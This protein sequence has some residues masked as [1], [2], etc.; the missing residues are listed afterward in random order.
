MSTRVGNKS[1]LFGLLVDRPVLSLMVTLAILSVG[2]MALWNL[3]LR[4]V[5]AGMVSSRI[6]VWVPIAQA[7]TPRE[8]E[9]KVV[10]PT[11]ELLKTIPGLRE[12]RSN[13]RTRS[14]RFWI[15]L[16]DDLD[17]TLASAEVRDR[18]QRAKQSWPE[19]V[20]RYFTWREDA[21]AMPLAFFQ[22]LTPERN[23]DW[24][25]RIEKVVQPRLEAV[26]GVGRVEVWGHLEESIRIWFDR[27]KLI[28]HRVDYRE[29][30][31]RLA[32]DNFTEPVG[33]LQ[34]RDQR[35]LL[36]V[37]S[38]F[39]SLEEI[40]SYPVRTG[41]LLRDIARIER[42]P[43]VRNSLSRFNQRFCYSGMIR[44]T[45]GTNPVAT[46]RRVRETAAALAAE[47]ELSGLD[48][49]FMLDQGALIED[50]LKTLLKSL[51]QGG[52][53]ALLVLFLF[54]RNV[55]AT[56]GIGVAIPFTLLI[57]CGWLFFTGSTLNIL[58]MAGMTLAVG[59]VVDNSV[60]VMENIRRLR[61]EGVPLRQ[62]CVEGAREVG[63]AIT[64][65]TLT[66][67]VVFLPMVFM[68]S[69][70][71]TRIMF[72]AVGI[73][74]SVALLGS[75]FVAL[76][77]LPAGIRNLSRRTRQA[78]QPVACSPVWSPA[79]WLIG[80]NRLLLR[81]CLKRRYWVLA[82]LLFYVVL[83]GAKTLPAPF[84]SL[85]MDTRGSGAFRRGDITVN[86]EMPRGMTLRDVV[87]Q[88]R[89]YEGYILARKEEWKVKAISVRLSRTY[90]R[91]DLQI[92]RDVSISE[93][94]ELANKIRKAWPR[95]P[96]IKMVLH[97]VGG[98]TDSSASEKNQRNFVVR[99]RGR[100]SEH[101]TAL[102]V[103]IQ[104][105]L[106]ALAEVEEA[107]IAMAEDNEEV[108]MEL[109]QDRMQE[110]GVLPE[111]LFGTVT[112]GLQ[113]R[114][115]SRFEESGR[116]LRLIAEFD[117]E[118]NPTL[119]D[120]KDTQIWSR[121]Q[122]AQSLDE[123]ARI[124]FQ[125]ALGSIFRR[126]GK[127]TVTLVGRRTPGVGPRAFS[128]ILKSNMRRFPMPKGYS[129]EEDSASRETERQMEELRDAGILSV[130]LIFLLM[131]ILFESIILPGAILVTIVIASVGAMWSL[132]FF[133]EG[134]CH[135]RGP[136][137]APAT[138][139]H[140]RR[141]DDRRPDADG[142]VRR[143]DRRRHQLRQHV[144]HGGGRAVPLH[145]LHRAR[146]GAD[147]HLPRRLLALAD[148]HLGSHQVAPR[149]APQDGASNA[150]C[151]L[152]SS[153]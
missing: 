5:P 13:S 125:K 40:E 78:Q 106:L 91:F 72:S 152:T 62:A 105:R 61:E 19:G 119:K 33:E 16:N 134:R 113:G 7:Q 32:S 14:A 47:P 132:K 38:K 24:D 85:D 77:L 111:V 140:D 68:S 75:L 94:P 118:R 15:N 79:A 127:T 26:E 34:G 36:R 100:D 124:R 55:R 74:L 66:T 17:P 71:A 6:N 60:V 99:L 129:W 138:D 109:D 65:A 39:R 150:I 137:R 108:V 95:R 25:H 57:V 147:L 96:G 31:T 29:L 117:S 120:L 84:P 136:P 116:E 83:T 151:F 86:L 149:P 42:V 110:L 93:V 12:I 130:I 148:G 153:M 122:S 8:V 10:K 54:L 76:L 56:L 115:I 87:D 4:L 73:P 131:A 53:L 49:R 63:L 114:E 107:E 92:P 9:E 143:G 97:N 64:V 11:E 67:V 1:R 41:L 101:L 133:Y 37:D 27:E 45:A 82:G 58:T 145:D 35:L 48:F 90:A 80:F 135:L 104:E 3:P 88:V 28:A 128:G 52:A 69:Q 142:A 43:T 81:L 144:D 103:K 46:S 44:A 121:R 112:A 18:L 146:G 21:T 126:D 50:S 51:A 22:M 98:E 23:A 30:I 139:L 2:A 89:S 59:M 20:D 123:M 141:D 70:T 102:G